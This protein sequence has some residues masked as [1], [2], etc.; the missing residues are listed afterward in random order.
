MSPLARPDYKR[1]AIKL[2]SA[3]FTDVR[4]TGKGKNLQVNYCT[5]AR[6][7][8]DISKLDI[9]EREDTEMVTTMF[10]EGQ[11]IT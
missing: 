9:P 1:H 3:T 6:Y 5:K 10:I 2:L 4:Q 7:L 8:S 11:Y